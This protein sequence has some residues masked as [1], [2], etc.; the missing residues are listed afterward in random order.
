MIKKINELTADY[1]ITRFSDSLP[2]TLVCGSRR[3][4]IAALFALWL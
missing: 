4:E 2:H 1:T 3:K